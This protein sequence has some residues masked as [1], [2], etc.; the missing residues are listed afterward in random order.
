M[1]KK[2]KAVTFSFD[3]G[4]ESDVKL[5]ELINKYN[6]KASFNLNSGLYDKNDEWLY[7]DRFL[8]KKLCPFDGK[9]YEG[10]EICVHGLYH[11][12]AP[13]LNDEE[14]YEEF[15][16][17]KENLEKVAKYPI[18]GA[19]YAYG[20][21][22]DRTVE[23]LNKIGIKYCRTVAATDDFSLQTDMLRYKA[24]CHFRD[25]DAFDK[26]NRFLEME[27]DSPQIMYI[28]G[29]SYEGDGDNAWGR[30]ED[31]FKLLSGKE[32]ILYGTNTQVFNYYDMLN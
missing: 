1:D 20:A 25:K 6:L 21:Y 32:D 4:N 7:N 11:R 13:E 14:L 29:H 30:M 22:D 10:H 9:L 12:A 8:V 27:A 28:W 17:D 31:I 3:D 2:L 5:V 23:I 15:A 18:L 24:S 19:A 16:K 26:I